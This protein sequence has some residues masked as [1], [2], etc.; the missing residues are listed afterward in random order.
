MKKF[1][2]FTVAFLF[3]I[4]ASPSSA[5]IVISD[6]INTGIAAETAKVQKIVPL[7]T[8]QR[9]QN[10]LLFRTWVSESIDLN[11]AVKRT[12]RRTQSSTFKQSVTT[13][14]LRMPTERMLLP[15]QPRPGALI[16]PQ[17]QLQGIRSVTLQKPVEVHYREGLTHFKYHKMKEAKAQAQIPTTEAMQLSRN[18]LIQNQFLQ[19]TE[20]DKVST[21]YLQTRRIAEEGGTTYITQQDIVFERSFEG[22]PVINSKMVVGLD[23]GTREILLIKHHNWTPMN[24]QATRQLTMQERTT[25]RSNSGAIIR[26][27]LEEKIRKTS[28]NFVRATV[29]QVIPA[30]FQA[31]NG[32]IPVIV[33]PIHIEHPSPRGVLTRDY[34]E[35]INLTGN[36]DDLF[37]MR[38]VAQGPTTSPR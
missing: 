36:D 4:I 32:L 20:V 21:A 7:N 28:G 38:S 23:P 34:L 30:W 27:R 15:K 16:T 29:K 22:K 24:K 37:G 26:Q 17:L 1:G 31:D 3:V 10:K 25:A 2:Y 14:K 5:D 18:F 19:E 11:K 35:V 8:L 6:Q 12:S 9:D 13:E 33:F